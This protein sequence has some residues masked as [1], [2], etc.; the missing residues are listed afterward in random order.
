MT[1]YFGKHL[2]VLLD[3]TFEEL[4]V[5]EGRLYRAILNQLRL[6]Y[7]FNVQ[8]YVRAIIQHETINRSSDPE[9]NP[10]YSADEDQPDSEEL[11]TQLLFAYKINPQTVLFLGY[12]DARDN[13]Y[14]DDLILTDRT[15]FFKLGYAWVL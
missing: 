8:T 3:T 13:E 11:F 2:K 7:Q 4:T 6:V 15:F 12:S 1:C 14:R 9:I 10:D 5:D